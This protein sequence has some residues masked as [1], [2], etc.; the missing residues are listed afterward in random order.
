MKKP[1][2]SCP[3]EFISPLAHPHILS[4]ED[5]IQ[6][7]YL[8]HAWDY[9]LSSFLRTLVGFGQYWT[10]I[11]SCSPALENSLKWKKIW[12]GK[13]PYQNGDISFQYKKPNLIW[14]KSSYQKK[15]N[16]ENDRSS[17]FHG[18]ESERG[19]WPWK[20]EG[21]GACSNFGSYSWGIEDCP[22]CFWISDD[23]LLTFVDL[24][25]NPFSL[26]LDLKMILFSLTLRW[27][28]GTP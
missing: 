3:Q 15:E 22:D 14:G 6:G 17:L 2:L 10:W 18:F 4:P 13:S 20:G 12:L 23:P 11:L 7:R 24:M 26:L 19:E 16:W 8:S 9:S 28:H 5:S 21:E 25:E 1:Q 27:D